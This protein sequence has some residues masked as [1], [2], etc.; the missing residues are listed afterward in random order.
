MI[1]AVNSALNTPGIQRLLKD[2]DGRDSVVTLVVGMAR[3]WLALQGLA[4]VGFTTAGV[5]AGND[6]ALIGI[7]H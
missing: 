3:P 5:T 7:Y 4:V 6:G 2:W 1:T